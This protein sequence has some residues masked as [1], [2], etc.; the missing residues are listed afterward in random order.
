MIG[1]GINKDVIVTNA[2]FSNEPGKARLAITFDYADKAKP[3]DAVKLSPFDQLNTAKVEDEGSSGTTINF[4]PFKVPTGPKNETKTEDEKIEMV[5]AD[6][7]K[8]KNQL[9]QLLEQYLKTEDIKWD[10]LY[11]T[12]ITADNYR[13]AFLDNDQL[14]KI[15]MNYST[16]FIAMITPF[17]ND[18]VYKLRL[19]LVRQ[20]KEK[21]YATIPSKFL[22]D[23]PYVD[24][25]QVPDE[26]TKVKF[27]DWEISN[28]LNDGKPI[29]QSQADGGPAAEAAATTGTP[30]NV[31]GNR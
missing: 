18:P 24:L 25:M 23:R 17:M 28:G 16:Q 2:V 13:S 4:F 30:G 5:N 1:V 14:A 3:K 7:V 11:N 27:S 9:T 29:Q 22:S 15:F 21:H 31:F 26:H 12:G 6:M 8:M 10:S 19:K 20:S